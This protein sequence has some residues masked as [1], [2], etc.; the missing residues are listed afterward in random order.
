MERSDQSP[1]PEAGDL[2][3]GYNLQLRPAA[4]CSACQANFAEG[5]AI[6]LFAALVLSFLYPHPSPFYYVTFGKTIYCAAV[7]IKSFR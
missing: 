5:F 4:V 7:P 3:G 2:G 6:R 1:L